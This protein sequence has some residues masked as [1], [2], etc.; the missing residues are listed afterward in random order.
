MARAPSSPHVLEIARGD[1]PG[2]LLLRGGR[3][4]SPSSREWVTTDL[5]IAGKWRSTTQAGSWRS[6]RFPSEVS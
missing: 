3:V 2:D 6:C 5:A 4:L 1:A